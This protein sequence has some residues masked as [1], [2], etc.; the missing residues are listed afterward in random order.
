M[1]VLRCQTPEMVRKEL[2]LYMLAYNVVRAVIL[3]AAHRSGLRSRQLS[4]KGVLQVV[5][6]LIPM[7][8]VAKDEEVVVALLDGLW[9]TVS[10]H[11]VGKRPNRI[12]PRAVKRRPKPHKLL[13]VPRHK[14]R[15]RLETGRL[16]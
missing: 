9:L 8:I 6:G 13:Q 14:A 15:K 16:A 2:W 1:D 11:R 4:F 7:L 5:N 12:E 10:A 3:R